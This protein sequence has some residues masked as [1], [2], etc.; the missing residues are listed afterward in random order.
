VLNREALQQHQYSVTYVAGVLRQHISDWAHVV[1][2]DDNDC[3]D[4]ITLDGAATTTGCDGGVIRLYL[5]TQPMDRE[6]LMSKGANDADLVWHKPD[7]ETQLDATSLDDVSVEQ[8]REICREQ[9]AERALSFCATL[10]IG[11][12]DEISSAVPRKVGVVRYCS[13]TGAPLDE[14]EWIITA[15]GTNLLQVLTLDGVD[16]TRTISNH[17]IEVQKVLG[18][19]AARHVLLDQIRQ[20][21]TFSDSYVDYRHLALLVDTMTAGGTVAPVSRHAFTKKETGPYTRAAFEQQ[22][23]VLTDAGM[24][25]EYEDGNDMRSAIM[26]GKPI[27]QGTGTMFE[28]LLSLDAVVEM[29]SK[30]MHEIAQRWE[31]L[32]AAEAAAQLP[33]NPFGFTG[34]DVAEPRK[35]RRTG[36]T[37]DAQGQNATAHAKAMTMPPSNPFFSSAAGADAAAVVRSSVFERQPEPLT[38]VRK[39]ESRFDYRPRSPSMFH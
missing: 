14:H 31:E 35:R 24:F 21:L 4:A 19:E 20:V 38:K 32:E 16:A 27:P 23:D 36:D 7:R 9:Y 34:N 17:A 13:E 29:P 1:A 28:T 12:I 5:L 39:I 18:I 26:M 8:W 3:G 30:T 6:L 25:A 33:Q 10:K 37:I 2:S 22:T 11:G 15:Q